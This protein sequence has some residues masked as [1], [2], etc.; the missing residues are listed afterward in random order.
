MDEVLTDEE[1]RGLE[2]CNP[3]AL[4]AP[5]TCGPSLTSTGKPLSYV[6]IFVGD[7]VGISQVT[8]PIAI[9]LE[10]SCFMLLTTYFVHWILLTTHPAGSLLP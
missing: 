1:P 9:E 2:A 4:N 7:F 3:S 6:D 10:G 8:L 5:N